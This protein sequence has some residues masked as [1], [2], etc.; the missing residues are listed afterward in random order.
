MTICHH[1]HPQ[2]KD[3]LTD[4]KTDCSAKDRMFFA[5]FA[6]CVITFEP[7]MIQTC[8]E[9]QNDCLNFSLVKDLKVV[10][11]KMTRHH[12]KMIGKTADSF[13]LSFSQHVYS[14]LWSKKVSAKNALDALWH[15]IRKKRGKVAFQVV[16]T[17]RYFIRQIYNS[18]VFFY[19]QIFFFT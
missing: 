6:F 3:Y 4:A 2:I 9:S 13:T 5:S 10:V 18:C 15:I 19:Q 11:E 17:S 1:S 14:G 16:T 7:I 12:H 8:S